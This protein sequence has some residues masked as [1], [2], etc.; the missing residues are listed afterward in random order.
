MDGEISQ[1]HDKLEPKKGPF[2]IQVKDKKLQSEDCWPLGDSL[3]RKFVKTHC[4]QAH[5]M[6][7]ESRS[8]E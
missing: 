6:S 4:F 5:S 8:S 3:H 1:N 7:V 2:F